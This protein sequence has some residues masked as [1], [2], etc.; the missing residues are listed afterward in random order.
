MHLEPTE[1]R[2]LVEIRVHRLSTS[3]LSRRPH[4]GEELGAAALV[5]P[6]LSTQGGRDGAGCFSTY[7]SQGHAR[8]VRIDDHAH[9]F[10]SEMLV[11]PTS[12]LHGQALLGLKISRKLIDNPGQLRKADDAV[13]RHVAD[14]GY[15]VEWQ[16]VMFAQRTKWNL[17]DEHQFVIV[18]LVGKRRE[19]ERLGG[20]QFGERKGNPPRRCGQMSRIG[21]ASKGDQERVY[22]PF[23][24]VKVDT[25]VAGNDPKAPMP[26]ELGITV[27]ADGLSRTQQGRHIVPLHTVLGRTQTLS[28]RDYAGVSHT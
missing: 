8:V 19:V 10:R 25:L 9:T 2:A 7:P 3:L 15:P 23:G 13:G 27:G 12:H 4:K 26:A 20:Q 6:K 11:Q 16:E 1:L 24:R 22:R 28:A 21:I 18:L 5:V 17:S 14:M